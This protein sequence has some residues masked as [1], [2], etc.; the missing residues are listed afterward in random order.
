MK[1]RRHGFIDQK[2]LGV[3]FTSCRVLDDKKR[4]KLRT[5]LLVHNND[6]RILSVEDQL[7]K[8]PSA[9]TPKFETIPFPNPYFA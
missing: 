5:I 2:S 1:K 4:G 8:T 9:K 7:P 3:V 6:T